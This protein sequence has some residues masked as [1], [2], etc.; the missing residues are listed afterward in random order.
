[1]SLEE[2]VFSALT[3]GSP[4][5]LRAYPEVMPQQVVLPAVTYTIIAGS[6]DFDLQGTTGLS[7]KL[8]QI[9]SW[10][11][12]RSG[13]YSQMVEAQNLMLASTAFQVTG[14]EETGAERYEPD[15]KLYRESREFVLWSNG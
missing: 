13:A 10:S 6:Y 3:S 7:R 4:S 2:D 1:M 12:T 8:V 11:T 15:T 5:A 14:V 9:D